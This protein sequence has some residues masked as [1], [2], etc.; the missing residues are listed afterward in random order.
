MK[1][2]LCNRRWK[3]RHSLVQSRFFGQHVCASHLEQRL[4]LPAMHIF[5]FKPHDKA[6]R[7]A[8]TC[9]GGE[10][11]ESVSDLQRSTQLV[12]GRATSEPTSIEPHICC[13]GPHR[14]LIFFLFFKDSGSQLLPVSLNLPNTWYSIQRTHKNLE[15]SVIYL[16]RGRSPLH[17]C[18]LG[19]WSFLNGVTPLSQSVSLVRLSW[20]THMQLSPC[21]AHSG[22]HCSSSCS[23]SGWVLEQ[24]SREDMGKAERC[25]ASVR[26]GEITVTSRRER[27]CFCAAGGQPLVLQDISNSPCLS[28]DSESRMST[29]NVWRYFSSVW[30]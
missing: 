2:L 17:A 30:P 13:A 28:K 19:G 15:F 1:W 6:A 9:F 11:S 20:F 26:D 29:G 18:S 3:Y 8:V 5:S 27:K 12:R 4:P 23:A 10:S 21:P 24:L 22:K 7:E 16:E 14:V 25:D